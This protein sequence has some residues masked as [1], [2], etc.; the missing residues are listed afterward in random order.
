LKVSRWQNKQLT[1]LPYL[2]AFSVTPINPLDPARLLC[3][4]LISPHPSKRLSTIHHLSTSTHTMLRPQSLLRAAA[5]ATRTAVRPVA[6]SQRWATT[7]APTTSSA[8]ANE[9]SP[10]VRSQPGEEIDPQ[11]GY[12][13]ASP[14]IGRRHDYT[15]GRSTGIKGPERQK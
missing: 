3:S 13:S 12:R 6:L 4:R 15:R 11:C 10:E 7:H 8:P 14:N 9:I 1:R 5:P 2:P